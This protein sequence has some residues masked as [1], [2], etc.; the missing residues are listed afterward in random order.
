[1]SHI[2]TKSQIILIFLVVLVCIISVGTFMDSKK[3]T[4][5]CK[6]SQ[7]TSIPDLYRGA[8]TP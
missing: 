2:Q 1:M 5:P 4:P 7:Y 6:P 3:K 8:D